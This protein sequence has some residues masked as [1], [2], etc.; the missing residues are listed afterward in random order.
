MQILSEEN[1]NFTF[2]TI[3]SKSASVMR[4]GEFEKTV[5]STVLCGRLK[6]IDMFLQKTATD[7][8]MF[9][10]IKLHLPFTA[11]P[12]YLK[13]VKKDFKS[14]QEKQDWPRG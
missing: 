9:I 14:F 7:K 8:Y 12:P 1:L 6:D 11:L 10:H 4:E 3:D 5:D 13:N 2:R